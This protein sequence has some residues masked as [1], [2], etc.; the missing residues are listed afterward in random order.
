[1]SQFN[2]SL[3]NPFRTSDI[4]PDYNSAVAISGGSYTPPVNG[5]IKM[6][7]LSQGDN[8]YSGGVVHTATGLNMVSNYSAYKYS[9]GGTIWCFVKAGEQYTLTTNQ[10]NLMFVPLISS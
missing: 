10:P 9:N 2:S 5:I 1:M 7:H 8:S 6:G 3:N 4:M